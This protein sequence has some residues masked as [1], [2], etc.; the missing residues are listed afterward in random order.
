MELSAEVD[1]TII[2]LKEGVGVLNDL[3]ESLGLNSA[4]RLA[5]LVTLSEQMTGQTAGLEESY[6]ALSDQYA[7]ALSELDASATKLCEGLY[8]AADTLVTASRRVA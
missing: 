8:R 1:R 5:Q 4:A 6:R 2:H 3:A 7:T